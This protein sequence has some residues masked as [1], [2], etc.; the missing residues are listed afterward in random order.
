MNCT[1]CG[2]AWERGDRFCQKCGNRLGAGQQARGRTWLLPVGGVLLAAVVAVAL[3]ASDRSAGQP[4]DQEYLVVMESWDGAQ[5]SRQ[6]TTAQMVEQRQGRFGF[7]LN[8]ASL[9]GATGPISF[10]LGR[11]RPAVTVSTDAARPIHRGSP[12]YALASALVSANPAGGATARIS[13]QVPAGKGLQR[14]GQLDLRFRRDTKTALG[15]QWE[16]ATFRTSTARLTSRLST[17]EVATRARG[18][19][20]WDKLRTTLVVADVVVEQQRGST[21]TWSRMS[22]VLADAAGTAAVL[23]KDLA[24]RPATARSLRGRPPGKLAMAELGW[25]TRSIA[26]AAGAE[27]EGAR[28]PV[29]LTALAVVYLADTA[30]TLVANMGHDLEMRRSDP[31][32]RFNPLDGDVESPLERYVLR[33]A[34]GGWASLAARLGLISVDDVEGYAVWGGKVLHFTGSILTGMSLQHAA[35]T[36]VSGKGIHLAHQLWGMAAHV[37]G[38]AK[39]ALVALGRL[40]YYGARLMADGLHVWEVLD[41]ALTASRLLRD[42]PWAR[43]TGGTSTTSD[44]SSCANACPGLGRR[45][46]AGKGFRI[47]GDPDGDGCP[48]WGSPT[49]CGEGKRCVNG[50][51]VGQGPVR[52]TLTWDTDADI[53]IH[54]KTPCRSTIFFRNKTACG[55][56][57]D[58]DDR[59]NNHHG[60]PGG[61]ENVFW[62]AAPA[63]PGEYVVYVHHYARCRGSGPTRYQVKIRQGGAEVTRSGVLQPGGGRGR[64]S[65]VEVYRF[66]R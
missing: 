50:S 11:G 46:C 12:H 32:H 8:G 53:D 38:A 48:E 63:R 65:K 22:V 9:S 29:L 51:C 55:G 16:R 33:R 21:R 27:A 4:G 31:S 41:Q 49:S 25:V 24:D 62:G 1:R 44:G 30:Y 54:V 52:M 6:I 59:C 26:L 45:E 18:A 14:L 5:L 15:R 7:R 13:V 61:P 35:A 19:F 42:R 17:D 10:A 23:Y 3:V 28:N 57:L 39:T 66:S 47:C 58:V 37:S 2:K 64:G 36:V 43:S 34:A 20:V 56:T 60:A 40:A